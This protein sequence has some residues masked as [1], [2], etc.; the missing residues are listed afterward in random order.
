ML[1]SQTNVQLPSRKVFGRNLRSERDRLS[2]S[3]LELAESAGLRRVDIFIFEKG[4]RRPELHQLARLAQAG[5]SLGYLLKGVRPDQ[6]LS[7]DPELDTDLSALISDYCRS[8]LF[9][10]EWNDG[11]R[12]ALRRELLLIWS[13]ENW[14]ST[15]MQEPPALVTVQPQPAEMCAPVGFYD[16][17]FP[18]FWLSLGLLFIGCA[19][20]VGL[21]AVFHELRFVSPYLGVLGLCSLL[22]G[23]FLT[24]RGLN[25]KGRA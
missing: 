23:A 19:I 24:K 4:D 2:L 3:Q 6:D 12:V 10:R 11:L 15:P 1:D 20:A 9:N 17:Q 8:S 25:R 18:A 16:R 22:F 14:L 5:V 21:L 13:D 7:P